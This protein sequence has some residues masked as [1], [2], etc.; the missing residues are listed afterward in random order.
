MPKKDQIIFYPNP[1]R[2]QNSFR[3]KDCALMAQITAS[4]IM[5]FIVKKEKKLVSID[6]IISLGKSQARQIKAS[7]DVRLS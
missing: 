6:H 1:P 4:A 2:R 3:I 7:R 5:I